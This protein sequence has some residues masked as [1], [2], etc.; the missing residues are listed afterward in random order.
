MLKKMLLMGI[1]PLACIALF[2]VLEGA[3]ALDPIEHRIYDFA[4]SLRPAVPEDPAIVFVNVDDEALDK[5]KTVWPWP[6]DYIAKGLVVLTEFG[7][8]QAVFD[9]L[10][11]Q[12]SAPGINMSRYAGV[13]EAYDRVF[14]DLESNFI[15]LAQAL[16]EGSIRLRD[17]KAVVPMYTD[18]L[19][20]AKQKLLDRMNEIT[21][22]RDLALGRAAQAFGRAFMAA[23]IPEEDLGRV[24]GLDAALA[25][26]LFLSHVTEENDRV[27]EAP[28]I[29]FPVTPVLDGARGVGFVN[30]KP[31]QPDGIMRRITLFYRKDGH[32]IP[33]LGLA[34]LLSYLGDPSVD[35]AADKVVLKGAQVPG[36]GVIDIV[37]PLAEDGT[38]LVNWSRK[39]TKTS[40]RPLS[41]WALLEYDNTEADLIYNL[42]I[43]ASL[44]KAGAVAVSFGPDEFLSEFHQP[45]EAMKK[46]LRDGGGGVDPAAYREQHAAFIQKL[47]EFLSAANEAALVS[48]IATGDK[49]AAE[50]IEA[51]IHAVFQADRERLL[52]QFLKLRER[53]AKDLKNSICITGLTA[54]TT[55]D[56]GV[57]P[58]EADFPNVGMHATVINTI[59]Q[60]QFLDDTPWWTAVILTA[61]FTLGVFFLVSVIKNPLA[62]VLA[63]AGSLLVCAGGLLL[64][65]VLTGVY[66]HIVS[67]VL[68]TLIVFVVFTVL[69]FLRTAKE[70]NFIRNAFTRY[71]SKE[72]ISELIA[73]PSKLNLGGEQ[74]KLTAL[75]T[76]IKGFSGFSELLTPPEL[77]RL[78]NSYFTDMGNII[79]QLSGTLD[80]YVGDAI[81]SFF[82][83]PIP[84]PQHAHHACLAAVRMKKIEKIMNDHI[85]EQ[86]LSPKPLFT[87][88]GVNTG[89]MLVGNMGSQD[90]LNYTIMGHHVNL[91]SRLE[92]V[93]KQYG[94]WILMSES[95][96]KEGGQAFLTRRLDRVRVV[97]INTPVRLYELI[98]EKSQVR[99]ELF[100]V[101]ELFQKGLDVFEKRKWDEARALFKQALKLRPDD[102]PSQVYLKRC[103]E[104]KRKPPSSSWDGVFSLT[105]K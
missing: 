86:K 8:S 55:T 101:V 32:V 45:I 96:Y 81:V 59:L 54:A 63:G 85:A 12:P 105:S 74:K 90:K 33:Q 29:V 73:D 30:I 104:Y 60:R 56:L 10:Y 44:Q 68:A 92:G 94:T 21:L 69:N 70:K 76:D 89:D 41:F 38:M 43:I 62:S 97:G 25:R 66:P 6:R 75:F 71:V 50:N 93:N 16:S 77:V 35:I 46:G 36:A 31:D 19:T 23:N 65:F 4:L 102:G 7:A 34:A 61:V 14:R 40:F 67:P 82:G 51:T 79:L 15:S 83:A 49:A 48:G 78:L 2:S 87:R 11:D 22:D 1:I 28:D 47:G 100:E 9:I 3:S 5:S 42:N 58:F 88:I 103:Q 72:V 84:L 98:D 37:I 91:A 39:T 80:K 26:K 53:L 18:E 20:S 27:P 13:N 57:T 64:F 99:P 17:L 95:T 52:P 24:K